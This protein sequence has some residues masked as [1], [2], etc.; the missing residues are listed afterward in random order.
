MIVEMSA[1][2]PPVTVAE[3]ATSRSLTSGAVA[4]DES[5]SRSPS[6][7]IAALVVPAG[8]VSST[9][10]SP[11]GAVVRTSARVPCGIGVSLRS[12]S[13]TCAT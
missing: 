13:V 8:G 5:G 4:V 3:S 10:A 9:Y 12:R 1:N 7:S 2:G 11:I 6:V